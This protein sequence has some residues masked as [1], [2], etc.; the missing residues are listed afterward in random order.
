MEEKKEE[1]WPQNAFSD[2]Q[3]DGEAR[4]RVI[5]I[6]LFLSLA[7]LLSIIFLLFLK[8]TEKI[9]FIFLLNRKD[10]IFSTKKIFIEEIIIACKSENKNIKIYS[11]KYH[12]NLRFDKNSA[13]I[14]IEFTFNTSSN[15]Y[16]YRINLHELIRKLGFVSSTYFDPYLSKF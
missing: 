16:I 15:N 13:Y 3:T 11:E 7:L 9:F 4:E 10:A 14:T 8:S 2:Q 6:F 1:N 5:Y 12:S